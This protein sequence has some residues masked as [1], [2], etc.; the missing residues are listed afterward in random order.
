MRAGHQLVNELVKAAD[1]K[2]PARTIARGRVD[3]LCIDEH[4]YLELGRR[5]AELP[6][7]LLIEQGEKN[8]VAITT[9]KSFEKAHMFGEPV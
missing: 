9:D 2:Q 1:E 6:L 5:K 7:H 8:S 3:L 4:H